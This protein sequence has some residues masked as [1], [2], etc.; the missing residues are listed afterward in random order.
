M[1][2]LFVYS[3]IPRRTG[4]AKITLYQGKTQDISGVCVSKGCTAESISKFLYVIMIINLRALFTKN[5][6]SFRLPMQKIS[7]HLHQ[8]IQI[9]SYSFSFSPSVYT[10]RYRCWYNKHI[11]LR[12]Y[13]YSHTFNADF[14]DVL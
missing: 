2:I 1:L 13:L 7:K 4:I 3:M 14:N 11:Q 9:C 12:N 10:Y 6:H 5:Y 8:N